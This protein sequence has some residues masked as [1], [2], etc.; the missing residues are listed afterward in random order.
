MMFKLDLDCGAQVAFNL[1]AEQVATMAGHANVAEY[2]WAIGL[3]NILQDS[4]ASI[5][6]KDF[7]SDDEWI[8]AKRAKAELKLGALMNGEV[9][10]TR[11]V[12]APR[13]S[14]F[15]AFARKWILAK[16]RAKFDRAAWKAKTEGDDGAAFIAA[17]VEKNLPKFRPEIEKDFAE[18]IEAQ[19]REAAIADEMDLDI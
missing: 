17:L 12:R 1:T 6:R 13:L 4:H 18:F 10:S 7:E 3:K 5:V 11:A 8:A 19:K 14:D 16:A 15:D 9:R 2:V